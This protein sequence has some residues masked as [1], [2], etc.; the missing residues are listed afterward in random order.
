MISRGSCSWCI[1]LGNSIITGPW[2]SVSGVNPEQ[3]VPDLENG[4][5]N[6]QA[7]DAAQFI[8]PN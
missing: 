4:V 1:P 6:G 2:P 3:T 5:L 7:D 8:N